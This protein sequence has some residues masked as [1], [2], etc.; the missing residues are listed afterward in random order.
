M[1][2]SLGWFLMTFGGWL[3]ARAFH[4]LR[5]AHRMRKWPSVEGHVVMSKSVHGPDG[6]TLPAVLYDYEVSGQRY[7]SDVI[8][9]GERPSTHIGDT[10]RVLEKYKQGAVVSAFHDPDSPDSA[11]LEARKVGFISVT[12]LAGLVL[13]ALGLAVLVLVWLPSS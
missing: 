6:E 10:G 12:S 8:W 2:T 5:G 13:L 4:G 11:F 3:V 9:A 7:T 1:M